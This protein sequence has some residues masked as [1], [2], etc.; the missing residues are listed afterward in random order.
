MCIRMGL[1]LAGCL[2]ANG[3]AALLVPSHVVS[4][5]LTSLFPFF[6]VSNAQLDGS[7]FLPTLPLAVGHLLP[8]LATFWPTSANFGGANFATK[9][10]ANR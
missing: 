1:P 6:S 7:F 8:L 5:H 2:A 3:V 9:A 10:N 4:S